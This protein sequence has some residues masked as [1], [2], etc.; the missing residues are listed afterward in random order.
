MGMPIIPQIKRIESNPIRP[1]PVDIETM[2][3]IQTN[4][5]GVGN[6]ILWNTYCSMNKEELGT[7][8]PPDRSY[9]VEQ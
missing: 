7:S 9:L 5:S 3:L 6:K 1:L 8:Y 2:Q 4:P